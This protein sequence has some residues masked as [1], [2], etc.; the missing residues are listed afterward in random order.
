MSET[1]VL[2]ISSFSF[3]HNFSYFSQFS[4]M[5]NFYLLFILHPHRHLNDF[6]ISIL[7]RAAFLPLSLFL[8][9]RPDIFDSWF[10]G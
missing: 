9:N 7:I 8:F 3:F 5:Y 2:V 1:V 10:V 6:N 4:I